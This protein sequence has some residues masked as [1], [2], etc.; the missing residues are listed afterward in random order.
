MTRTAV[1]W[2]L[3]GWADPSGLAACRQEGGV[4]QPGRSGHP[5]WCGCPR[6][7]AVVRC[8]LTHITF[9]LNVVPPADVHKGLEFVELELFLCLFDRFVIV[10]SLCGGNPVFNREPLLGRGRQQAGQGD[11]AEAEAGVWRLADAA[12]KPPA[13]VPR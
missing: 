7:A 12:P 3:Q 1:C 5:R 9:T 13:G 4:R 6:S 10:I 11:P 2:G 8:G